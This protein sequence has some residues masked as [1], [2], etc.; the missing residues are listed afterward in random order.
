MR[1]KVRGQ[2]TLKTESPAGHSQ[3]SNRTKRKW[4]NV[5]IV[6]RKQQR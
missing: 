3:D 5:I 6:E 4:I 2:Y 1:K